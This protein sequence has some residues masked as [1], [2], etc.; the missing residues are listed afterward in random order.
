M[1]NCLCKK[2]V[3]TISEFLKI[4]E[5]SNLKQVELIAGRILRSKTL[6]RVAIVT[7]ALVLNLST[8]GAVSAAGPGIDKLGN[9]LINLIRGYAY[10]VLIIMAIV[11]SIRAAVSGD[12]KKVLSILMRYVLVFVL[13]YL[14]PQLFDAIKC[15]L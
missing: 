3:M 10:Y 5:I 7:I 6:K 1:L 8:V 12:S 9:L 2:E 13:M 4:E 14:I 15:N 11:E